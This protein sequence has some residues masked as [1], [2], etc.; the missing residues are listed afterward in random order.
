[1]L[2]ARLRIRG[3]PQWHEG[4]DPA[5]VETCCCARAYSHRG[6][7]LCTRQLMPSSRW[8]EPAL[9]CYPVNRAVNA[10][11]R[12]AC[13][14]WAGWIGELMCAGPGQGRCT[15]PRETLPAKEDKRRRDCSGNHLGCPLTWG[16]GRIAVR[17][18]WQSGIAKRQR[19]D[20]APKGKPPDRRREVCCRES[21]PVPKP[22]DLLPMPPC[23]VV[24]A[25]CRSGAPAPAI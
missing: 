25:S 13:L 5:S 1:M 24:N 11:C 14:A 22:Q 4:P 10:V 19:R 8:Q 18:K 20:T 2:S 3:A 6:R 15:D 12:V 23:S 7:D 17:T 16:L 9:R 21:Q